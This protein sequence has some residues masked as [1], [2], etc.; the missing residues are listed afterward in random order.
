MGHAGKP[1]E[2]L[3]ILGDELWPI[4]GNNSRAGSRV[5]LLGPFKNDFYVSFGHLLSDLPM[6]DGTAAPIQE[7]AQVVEGATDVEI[8]DINM[9]VFMGQQ[10]LNEAG[11]FERWLLVP[12]LKHACF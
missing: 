6:D 7:A 1:D 9:P 10:R 3:E 5:F 12:L 11:S 4:V 8:R 2:F